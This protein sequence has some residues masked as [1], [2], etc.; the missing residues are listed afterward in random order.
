MRLVAIRGAD[1]AGRTPHRRGRG[2]L[3][4]RAGREHPHG[5]GHRRPAGHPHRGLDAGAARRGGPWPPTRRARRRAR[6]PTPRTGSPPPRR[7][8]A[9]PAAPG[10]ACPRAT[11]W[12]GGRAARP[13]SPR[14]RPGRCR[15][16]P[17]EVSTDAEWRTWSRRSR[18]ACDE[19]DELGGGARLGHAGR[20]V[21]R[22]TPSATGVGTMP[23]PDV[24]EQHT[25]ARRHGLAAERAGPGQAA[26]RRRG[27][28]APAG[29][30]ARGAARRSAAS[31]NVSELDRR[32]GRRQGGGGGGERRRPPGRRAR[33]PTAPSASRTSSGAAAPASQAEAHTVNVAEGQGTASG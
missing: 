1:R 29:A 18:S 7:R 17:R 20:R 26:R 3:D 27:R 6:R 13:R 10:R 12:R 32:A 9:A 16:T 5:L 22:S 8:A 23:E 19:R 28:A 4:E 15:A 30:G 21:Q 2:D 25:L 33:R 14:A 31:R 24:G 11:A